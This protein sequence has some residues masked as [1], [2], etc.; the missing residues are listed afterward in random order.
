MKEW[1]SFL[2]P[3]VLIEIVT[4]VLGSQPSK[5]ELCQLFSVSSG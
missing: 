3:L 4:H 2:N 5:V 1:W